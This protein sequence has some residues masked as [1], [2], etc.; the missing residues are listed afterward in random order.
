MSGVVMIGVLS[1]MV[2]GAMGM[3]MRRIAGFV[4]VLPILIAPA[5]YLYVWRD[6][7]HGPCLFADAFRTVQCT[8]T[9]DFVMMTLS[10]TEDALRVSASHL[11]VGFSVVLILTVFRTIIDTVDFSR[12][13]SARQAAQPHLS[14]TRPA[15]GQRPEGQAAPVHAAHGQ[16]VAGP[17]GHAPTPPMAPS[18]SEFEGGLLPSFVDGPR[19]TGGFAIGNGGSVVVPFAPA[20]VRALAS[21]QLPPDRRSKA[22]E[23]DDM[24]DDAPDEDADERARAGQPIW[25]PRARQ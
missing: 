23:P 4:I 21:G 24:S 9:R 14:Q 16:P 18:T 25:R 12:P 5:A 19:Q 7:I 3:I 22:A 13:R 10:L 8:P 15:H 6:A 11:V 2:F 17:A 20:T 1:G